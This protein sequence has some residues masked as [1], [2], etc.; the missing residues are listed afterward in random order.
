MLTIITGILKCKVMYG[1]TEITERLCKDLGA[2]MFRISNSSIF[3]VGNPPNMKTESHKF[4]L[5]CVL[6]I[7]TA[8]T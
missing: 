5:N 1:I 4:P 7:F 3:P 8:R 6:Q 2:L